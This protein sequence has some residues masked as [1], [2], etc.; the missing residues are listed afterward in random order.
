MGVVPVFGN[1]VPGIC[2]VMLEAPSRHNNAERHKCRP[3]L[4][5]PCRLISCCA[6]MTCTLFSAAIE[7]VR[8]LMSTS[9]KKLC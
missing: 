4:E 1:R 7:L 6:R 2:H 5:E 8:E 3:W 9:A